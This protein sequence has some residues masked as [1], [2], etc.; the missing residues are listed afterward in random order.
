MLNNRMASGPTLLF[1]LPVLFACSDSQE[2]LS[3]PSAFVQAEIQGAYDEQYNTDRGTFGFGETR[4]EGIK[5][6]TIFSGYEQADVARQVLVRRYGDDQFPAGAYSV[7]LIDLQD[8][9][10]SGVRFEFWR[11]TSWGNTDAE[12]ERFAADSGTIRITEAR[13]D[14]VEGTFEVQAFRY[15]LEKMGRYGYETVDGPCTVPGRT[16][17]GGPRLTITGHFLVVPPTTH[18]GL[19]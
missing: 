19:P 18:S 16:A 12:R 10:R 17:A 1:L 14:R 9:N 13:T 3:P 7:E 8:P 6:F 2:L 5:T 11:T 4:P 15:C